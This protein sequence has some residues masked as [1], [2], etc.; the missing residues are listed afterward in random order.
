[1]PSDVNEQD[2]EEENWSM[3]KWGS[4]WKTFFSMVELKY[5]MPPIWHNVLI[6]IQNKGLFYI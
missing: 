2:A 5:T 1:M 4:G 6:K 3:E